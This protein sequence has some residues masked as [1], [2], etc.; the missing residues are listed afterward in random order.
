MS[1]S[2]RSEC[3]GAGSELA[4]S[5]DPTHRFV[6]VRTPDG[7]LQPVTGDGE[8]GAALR[9]SDVDKI[10][11]TGSTRTGKRIMA[12][13]AEA[14]T[15]VRLECG[16]KDPVIIAADADLDAAAQAV[17]WGAFTNGGQTCVGVERVCSTSATCSETHL[18]QQ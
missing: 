17:A 8:T 7:V 12:Q 18:D 9:D 11:F 6:R 16:G 2:R 13:C 4:N 14:L 1:A 5:R 15:P 10:G 3:T